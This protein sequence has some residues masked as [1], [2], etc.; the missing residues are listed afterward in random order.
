MEIGSFDGGSLAVLAPCPPLPSQFLLSFSCLPP[1][2]PPA[3][4]LSLCS[5][6]SRLGQPRAACIFLASLQPG[7]S[8][9]TVALKGASSSLL[10]SHS[11]APFSGHRT[12][13]IEKNSTWSLV[14]KASPQYSGCSQSLLY[15]AV[16]PSLLGCGHLSSFYATSLSAGPLS[17]HYEEE[18]L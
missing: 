10:P 16:C 12:A 7:S 2:P 13:K 4:T 14:A 1:S 8:P 5:C 3:G 15:Y 17:L 18:C 6:P 11:P 9:R